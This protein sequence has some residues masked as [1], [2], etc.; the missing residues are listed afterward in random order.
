MGRLASSP[1]EN[2]FYAGEV[3][4]RPCFACDAANRIYRVMQF[5]TVGQCDAAAQVEPLQKSVLAAI[6]RR[7]KQLEKGQ[8]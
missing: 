6:K 3:N 1:Q 4:G 2:P 8:P 7:R 5:T